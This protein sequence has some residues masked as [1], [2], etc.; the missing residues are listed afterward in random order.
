MLRK[1]AIFIVMLVHVNGSMFLPQVA[2]TD[3][4]N[5]GGQQ[6]NDI[7]SVLEYVDEVIMGNLDQTPVDEDNDQGQNFHLVKLVDYY[8]EI[9]FSPVKQEPISGTAKNSYSL[10]REA[11]VYPVSLEI[12]AP[13]P[14][15]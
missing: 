9:D 14:K 10:F 12:P 15:A 6:K 2:E 11:A 5:T 13:P 1:F 7:N 8:F 4:Y 3:M